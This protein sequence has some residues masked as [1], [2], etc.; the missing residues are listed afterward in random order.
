MRVIVPIAAAS[1]A[2]TACGG[3]TPAASPTS[4]PT[5]PLDT[6]APSAAPT[7]SSGPSELPIGRAQTSV[8][9]ETTVKAAVLHV[10]QPVTVGEFADQRKGYEYGAIEVKLCVTKN[11]GEPAEVGWAAWALTNPDGTVTRVLSSYNPNWFS[12]PLYPDGFTVRVGK[13]V[14][15]WIPYQAAKGSK[16]ASVTYQPAGMTAL[17]WTVA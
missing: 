5:V 7:A 14:R 17:E 10:R 13:C 2:L 16:P 11:T 9:D 8:D 15:G 3:S 12:V 6:P 1:F 4:A